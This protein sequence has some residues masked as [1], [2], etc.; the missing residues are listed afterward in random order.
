MFIPSLCGTTGLGL[1]NS[2]NTVLILSGLLLVGLLV[3]WFVMM[4]CVLGYVNVAVKKGSS[5]ICNWKY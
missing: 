4:I 1:C 3:S 5:M 2:Y